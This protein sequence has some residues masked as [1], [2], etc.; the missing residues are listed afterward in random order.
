MFSAKVVLRVVAF[1]ALAC[2]S[3]NAAVLSGTVKDPSGSVVAN[4]DV[5]IMA[6]GSQ[7]AL[8]ARCG[9]DGRFSIEIPPGQYV[10]RVALEK[11]KPFSK[12]ITIADKGLESLE[13]SLSLA[14]TQQEVSVAGT[15]SSKSNSDPVYRQ[16]RDAQ[17]Q[18]SY[19]VT[20]LTIKRDVGTFLLKSGT[21]TFTAPVLGKRTMALFSG[22]GE[23]TLKPQLKL[24]A[25]YMKRTLDADGVQE[26]F[27]KLAIAFTD[28][29]Y[30]EIKAAG[31]PTVLDPKAGDVLH[32]VQRRLRHRIENSRSMME[33]MLSG[34]DMENIEAEILAD[35][36]NP[37]RLG[38]FRAYIFGQKNGDLRFFVLP[39]GA[40]S[41]LPS[42]E[43]V[44]L[45][46]LDPNGERDGMWYLAH[47]MTEFTGKNTGPHVNMRTIKPLHYEIET[48]IARNDHLT[49]T[50]KLR[51]Q[52][53]HEGDRV[54]KFGLLPSLRVDTVT[55]NGK[56]IP[57]IQE[58]RKQDGSFYVI[59]PA[60]MSA[61]QEYQLTMEYEGNK[62]LSNEGGGN[63]AVG[64]RTSWYPSVNAFADQCTYDLTFKVPKKYTIVGVGKLVKQWK[65]DNYAAS[66][67][68]SDIPLSVAGFN[69]GEFK[70]KSAE[71]DVLKYS[72][73][74]YAASEMPDYLRNLP[75]TAEASPGRLTE[76]AMGQ[77][78]NAL[79]VFTHWFGPAPYGRIAITQ[80][81]EFNFGQSWP[82]LVYLP[83][84]AFLD[85]TQR[86][87]LMGIQNRFSEFIQEVTP[88]EV[89]H[90]WWGHMVGWSTFHDQW[91][92]E[93]F[94]DFSAGLYLQVTEKSPDKYLK[95][96]DRSRETIL[97]KNQFGRRANDAGPIWQGLRLST[98]KNPQAYNRIVYP[99]GGYVLHMLRW[100]MYDPATGDADFIA[101]MKDFVQTYMHKTAS[102][103][104]FYDVVNKHIKPGMDLDGNRQLAWFFREW[105]YGTEIPR[106]EFDY[107]LSDN[108][109]GSCQLTG[110]LTQKD[111][112]A[113]FKML[114]PIYVEAD[115]KLTQLGR[116]RISGSDKP[117]NLSVK[118]QTRPKRVL[119]NANYDVLTA[120]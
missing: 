61:K 34:E 106:Y 79:R 53:I 99:K 91:L 37:Q 45:L 20:D 94:A 80:Q 29:S 65:E 30:D 26:S 82:T 111:V 105:V 59:M 63:F 66:Q 3:S 14:E 85:A 96:W 46:N 11:F 22:E 28:A 81:P 42:P 112:S 76:V 75:G 4:V 32:D 54:I 77:A 74:G 119:I 51:F 69:Y 115:G 92:S 97:E 38:S 35:L 50:A 39:L 71:D 33:A 10:I 114:V 43:E 9:A 18:E 116:A 41:T 40:M 101:M 117:V 73:E 109:D 102:T 89:A 86:W 62:V 13:L 58:G 2:S 78:Q 36:L 118:L 88:H 98:F 95:Y 100:M 52:A 17:P 1:L 110:T 57:F 24:E 104:D 64:A 60:P 47:N 72:V 84:S 27:R 25:D 16:L 70:K 5:E 21:V 49:A 103:E 19:M 68:K 55:F 93:G 23:F 6:A 113:N 8:H 87:Q 15:V 83:V 48:A 44:A 7:K 31:K 12:E 56:E 67:W 107:K 90:Q 108:S 120:K